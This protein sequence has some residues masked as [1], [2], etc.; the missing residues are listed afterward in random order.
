MS[1]SDKSGESGEVRRDRDR[2]VAF[3]FSA[4]D[5]FVELD[6][7]QKIR[8]VT[9]AVNALTGK[10]GSGLNGK[11]FL[12]LIVPEERAMVSAGFDIAVKQGRCGPMHLRLL[13]DEGEP[14]FLELR[15]T[16]LPIN[17]GGLFLS[18]NRGNAAI[19]NNVELIDKEKFAEIAHEAIGSASSG[20]RPAVLT[21][22]DLEGLTALI[23]RMD[24]DGAAR[25]MSDINGYIQAQAIDGGTAAHIGNDM[26]GV[27][28][29]PGTDIVNLEEM[30]TV[31]AKATDP[32]GTG[33]T[34]NTAS[35]DLGGE[36][37]SDFDDAKALLYTI[38]KFSEKR[39]K[40]TVKDLQQ[41]Y[42][43][44]LEEV[45]GKIVSFKKT[46]SAGEFEVYF[47]PIVELTSRDVDHYEALL[48]LPGA[49]AEDSPYPFIS[50]AEDA[51]VIADF[52]LAMCARVM[53][54]LESVNKQGRELSVAINVSGR[55]LE[56]PAFL[57]KL[58]QLLGHFSPPRSWLQFEVTESSTIHDL[59][60]TGKFLNS[61]R[62][63]GHAV[64]L[65]D[66]GSGSAAFQYL[67]ALDVDCVKIDGVYVQEAQDSA[68]GKAFLRT[69]ATLCKDLEIDTVGEMVELE[70]SAD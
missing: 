41:G 1:S 28:H 38:N 34:V 30:I 69:I 11:K 12:D 49:G 52:D 51:G 50:F 27:V 2:F 68:R 37:L 64:C 35:V 31:R 8:Y 55:S 63:L 46:V 10:E 29:D 26:F 60:T 40:F 59:E 61:L 67:R 44:M 66:F 3:A 7:E 24:E 56:T 6:S 36:E 14:L 39:S 47:Q 43:T 13:Q 62:K 65:D 5:A 25:L 9:G 48:R 53:R 20:E 23:S 45:R 22:L 21:M 54:F 19:A 15:G 16:Y 4:A 70:A 57:E 18:L 42:Q 17:G 32:D 58:I 33:V